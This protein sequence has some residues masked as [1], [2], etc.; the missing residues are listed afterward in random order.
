MKR[1]LTSATTA[2]SAYGGLLHCPAR[3][4]PSG[5]DGQQHRPACG[6][7][8]GERHRGPREPVNVGHR[9]GRDALARADAREAGRTVNYND[10]MLA[11]R[12]VSLLALVVWVGGLVALGA[13]AAPVTFDVIAARHVPEGRLLAGAIFGVD[14]AAVPLRQL[15]VRRGDAAGADRT[16][17]PRPPAAAV[18]ATPGGCRGDARSRSSTRD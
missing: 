17:D 5:D 12:Y 16:G 3:Q 4:G 13:I 15:C 8:A 14:P 6:A 2:G 1:S 7:R 9:S 18:R 10:P 11:L